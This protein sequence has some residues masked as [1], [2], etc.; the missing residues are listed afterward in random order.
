MALSVIYRDKKHASTETEYGTE[1]HPA[2]WQI[3]S[4]SSEEEE[5]TL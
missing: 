4:T 5:R 1:D 2:S 3:I